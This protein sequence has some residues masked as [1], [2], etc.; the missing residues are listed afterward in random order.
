MGT[1]ANDILALRYLGRLPYLAV[2]STALTLFTLTGQAFG[3]GYEREEDPL[4]KTFKAVVLHVKKSDWEQ[5]DEAISSIKDRI[6]DVNTLFDV[7]LHPQL[8]TSIASK[9]T[10]TL[11][12]GMA[13]LVFLAIRE[14]F[15]WN[16][17]EDLTVF[18]K[19]KV[20]LRL[21]KEYYV[22]L[23]AG[24]VRIFDLKSG[25]TFNDTIYN[26][27]DRAKITLGSLGFFG[28]GAIKPN[29]KEFDAIAQ[30]IEDSL[31]HVFP[32]FRN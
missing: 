31:L 15:Y 4:I 27:F 10:Q 3:Y 22:T 1:D 16:H 11:M 12:R 8:S 9:D 20:R 25:T 24:N 13:N 17:A 14:K 7:N 23:L 18:S 21:A 29:L 6:D 2:L 26:E 30:T 5:V 32:Y 28:V 19:S